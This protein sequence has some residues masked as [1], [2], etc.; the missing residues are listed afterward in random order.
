MSSVDSGMSRPSLP[1]YTVKWDNVRREWAAQNDTTGTTLRGANQQEL[2]YAR[3]R[4]V[5]ELADD[6]KRIFEYAAAHGNTP[7]QEVSR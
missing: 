2:E 4:R 5:L 6:L 3:N 1:G 7:P